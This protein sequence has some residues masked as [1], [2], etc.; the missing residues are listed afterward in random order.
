VFHQ[1]IDA[2]RRSRQGLVAAVL[3]SSSRLQVR[4]MQEAPAGVLKINRE[5]DDQ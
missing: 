5:G 1:L 4:F 2:T 3:S